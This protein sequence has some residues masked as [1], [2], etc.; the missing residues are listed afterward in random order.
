MFEMDW[1]VRF[2]F[3]SFL[4][5]SPIFVFL[6]VLGF[7][8][9]LPLSVSL[10]VSVSCV[11]FSFPFGSSRFNFF[12]FWKY[13]RSRSRFRSIPGSGIL[14]QIWYLHWLGGER[15]DPPSPTIWQ[16]LVTRKLRVVETYSTFRCLLRQIGGC[17]APECHSGWWIGK[18]ILIGN[19]YFHITPCQHLLGCTYVP[20]LR[21]FVFCWNR[22]YH[23]YL[24]T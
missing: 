22:V 2:D 3:L 7:S 4:V 23:I 10:C 17:Y 8:S 18:D 15:H 13:W 11:L 21:D 1:N 12:L 16:I 24:T 14:G 19:P 5:Y 6:F 20:H 9:P